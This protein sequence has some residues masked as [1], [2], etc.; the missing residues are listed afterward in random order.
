VSIKYL[1]VAVIALSSSL[2]SVDIK[3]GAEDRK[4]LIYSISFRNLLKKNCKIYSIE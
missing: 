2:V 1:K 4:L 3:G